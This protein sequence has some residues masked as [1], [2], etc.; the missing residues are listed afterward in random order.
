MIFTWKMF[1]IKIKQIYLMM[2]YLI[3]I[4]TTTISHEFIDKLNENPSVKFFV[5]QKK[6]LRTVINVFKTTSIWILKIKMMIL[7]FN[8]HF[9][10]LQTEIRM[11]L[12]NLNCLLVE[13]TFQNI[14]NDLNKKLTFKCQNKLMFIKI[15]K[16]WINRT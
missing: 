13:S 9:N 10:K 8:I 5:T 2:I 4:Y 7:L 1:F 16:S 15:C 6:C 14:K 3:M 11:R 12:K